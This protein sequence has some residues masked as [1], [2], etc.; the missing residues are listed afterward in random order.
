MIHSGK[1]DIEEN[2]AESTR[3]ESARNLSE[4]VATKVE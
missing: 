4:K 3:N 2:E 1:H